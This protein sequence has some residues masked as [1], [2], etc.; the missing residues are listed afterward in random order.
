MQN[1]QKSIDEFRY[2]LIYNARE[3]AKYFPCNKITFSLV[4]IA[5]I[6]TIIWIVFL[7]LSPPEKEKVII[8]KVSISNRMVL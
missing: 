1:V 5:A 2:K 3:W 4:I 7:L 8:G 6:A